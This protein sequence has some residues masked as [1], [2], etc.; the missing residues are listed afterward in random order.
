MNSTISV[1]KGTSIVRGIMNKCIKCN[2]KNKRKLE[3]SM[4][5]IT[6][7]LR[8]T[9]VN[10]VMFLDASGPYLILK[11]RIRMNLRKK[12]ARLKVWVLHSTCAISHYSRAEIMADYSTSEFLLAFTRLCGVTGYPSVAYLDSDSSEKKGM[13]ETTF[14]CGDVVKGLAYHCNTELRFCGTLGQSHS[15]HG[16]IEARIKSF[17]KYMEEQ[18]E[19][20]EDMTFTMFQTAIGLASN[21]LNSCPLAL[22]RSSNMDTANFITPFTFLQGV[23]SAERIPLGLG[24][25][26]RREEILDSVTE[27]SKGLYSFYSAHITSFLLKSKWSQESPDE[28]QIGDIVLFE[29]KKSEMESKWKLGKIKTI[30]KDSDGEGR[31]VGVQYSNSSEIWYPTTKNCN[32]EIKVKQRVTRRGTHTIVKIYDI[33]ETSIDDDIRELMLNAEDS[34]KRYLSNAADISDSNDT[35]DEEETEQHKEQSVEI[36]E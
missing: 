22:K 6:R 29:H 31:I 12:Q 11:N 17:K 23:Q 20:V 35:N 15:R 30:E 33:S 4:G 21:I 28:L 7:R 5:P 8:Y 27:F 19:A 34:E 13:T 24:T 2:L 14:N 10:N 9:Y 1:Y 16:A 18:F 36:G 32:A 26:L 3:T 25:Q